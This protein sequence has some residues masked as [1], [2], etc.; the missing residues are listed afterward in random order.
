MNRWA[1]YREFHP[2]WHR[3]RMSTYWWLERWGYIAFILRELS[4]VF[5]AWFVV[6]LL[7]LVRAVSQGDGSYQQF[8]TWSGRRWILL[9]NLVSL[10]FVVY[11]SLTWFKLAPQAMVVHFRGE[12][13]PGTWIATANYLA[14]ALVSALVA[15]ILMGG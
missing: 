5:V 14:W 3:P 2:R 9:L 15:W 13:V 8:L 1:G 10:L 4:S 6:Y 12:R 11:H 7:L